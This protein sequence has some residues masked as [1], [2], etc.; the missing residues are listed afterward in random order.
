[1]NTV[2][3]GKFL[4][5]SGQIAITDPTYTPQT[6]CQAI[7]EVAGGTWRAEVLKKDN[8]I[9]SFQAIH[10]DYASPSEREWQLT[11]YEIGI[12]S[13]VVGMYDAAK[14]LSA[15]DEQNTEILGTSFAFGTVCKPNVNNDNFN[16]YIATSD[17]G[18]II[19]LK[20]KF[21]Y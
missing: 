20:I 14:Y 10:N 9:E 8:K 3:L 1:M 17:N 19:G 15:C 7:L 6:W 2:A 4:V 16:L 5:A 13:G 21:V 11:E 18:T 12:D